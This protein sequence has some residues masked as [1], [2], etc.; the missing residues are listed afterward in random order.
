MRDHAMVPAIMIEVSQLR[1]SVILSWAGRWFAGAPASGRGGTLTPGC[2]FSMQDAV[3]ATR[4]AEKIRPRGYR[5]VITTRYGNADEVIEVYIPDVEMPTFKVHRGSE[6]VLVTDCIG[7][8]LSFPTLT[9][10]LM[11]MVPLSRS[12]RRQVL[13]GMTGLVG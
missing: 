1:P 4:W 12:D 2:A 5:V 9:D 7:L 11:T 10:A 13:K 8:T 6:T 3:I